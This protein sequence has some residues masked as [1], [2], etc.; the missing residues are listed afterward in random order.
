MSQAAH[1][2]TT[3][4]IDAFSSASISIHDLP[5]EILSRI[6]F[7]TL[8]FNCEFEVFDKRSIDS[9]WVLGMVC[10]RWRAIAWQTPDLWSSFKLGW[11]LVNNRSRGLDHLKDVLARSRQA[12][13]S[14][15]IS[16]S[17][18]QLG[19]E[20][21]MPLASRLCNLR[22][23]CTLHELLLFRFWGFAG[24]EKIGTVD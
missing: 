23:V 18:L 13:L 3:D 24:F 2:S 14:T 17:D 12:P 21:F 16:S 22:I 7:F 20:P 4:V 5:P 9:P 19:L 10:S 6:F 8:P 11:H 15:S 1:N